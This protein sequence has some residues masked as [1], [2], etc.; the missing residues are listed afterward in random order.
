[1]SSADDSTLHKLKEK[2][3][4]VEKNQAELYH[5][6]EEKK[7]A[8][9]MSKI[10]D[11]F[12]LGGLIEIEASSDSNDSAGDTSDIVLATA[13]LVVEAEL[14]EF[15][16]GTIVLLHEEDGDNDPNLAVDEG[17]ITISS[18]SNFSLT[19]GKF[20]IPFGAYN[21]HFIS[22]PLTNVL[23]ET[24]VTSAM[25]TYAK[26]G[27]PF[28]VSVGIFNG[29]EIETGDKNKI[30]DFFASITATPMEGLT[31]GAYYLSDFEETGGMAG[32]TFARTNTIAGQGAFISYNYDKFTIEGEY[33]TAADNYKVTDLD[34]NNDGE[35]DKPS[36]YNVELAYHYNSGVEVALKVEGN[37]DFL[38]EPQRQYGVAV[39]YGLYENVALAFEVIKGEYDDSSLN[40]TLCTAQLAI[41]F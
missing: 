11:K 16:S 31:V 34:A 21:S 39:G 3:D 4:R 12:S 19:A 18:P 24:S 5:S 14:N 8:G 40:R 33:I 32:L 30:D 7:R 36:A 25:V 6:L 17:Y 23:G 22:K 29:A 37:T 38:G 41:E 35:G 2:L 26:E 9:L 27:A 15:V 10:S 13:S 28:E 20:A 1:M